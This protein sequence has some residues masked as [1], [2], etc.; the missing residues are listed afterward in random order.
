MNDRLKSP[1]FQVCPQSQAN[2][3]AAF[4]AEMT[5]ALTSNR[6][7]NLEI[8]HIRSARI[9]FLVIFGEE[10]KNNHTFSSYQCSVFGH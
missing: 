6:H 5:N 2:P 10:I 4:N 3:E 8:A 1:N 9:T 7:F